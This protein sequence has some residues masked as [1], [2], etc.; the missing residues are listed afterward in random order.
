MRLTRWTQKTINMLLIGSLLLPTI[1]H[2]EA[3]S[4]LS[5]KPATDRTKT[6]TTKD[7]IS[8]YQTALQAKDK[9]ENIQP[10]EKTT[11]TKEEIKQLDWDTL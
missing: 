3:G 9:Q 4:S 5:E 1:V 7:W 2:A 6:G 10:D 8:A 11:Y